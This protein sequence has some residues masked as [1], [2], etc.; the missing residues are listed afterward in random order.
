MK[1]VVT[2]PVFQDINGIKLYW[3]MKINY[4]SWIL[5]FSQLRKFK[6]QAY[7]VNELL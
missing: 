2:H 3:V 4:F 1:I 6:S 5:N 7:H